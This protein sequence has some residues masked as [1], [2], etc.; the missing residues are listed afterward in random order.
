MYEIRGVFPYRMR[1]DYYFDMI[2][3]SADMVAFSDQGSYV[4]LS[5]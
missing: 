5:T 3:A 1:F 2:L 4:K